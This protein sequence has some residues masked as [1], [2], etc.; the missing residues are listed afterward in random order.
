MREPAASSH[1]LQGR[2]AA[3]KSLSRKMLVRFQG[4]SEHS[5]LRHAAHRLAAYHG[6]GC[7]VADLRRK[8]ISL[9]MSM[10]SPVKSPYCST[11]SSPQ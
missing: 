3:V 10:G 1:G 11:T 5:V 6:A 8:I 9:Q 7:E 4:N 2:A